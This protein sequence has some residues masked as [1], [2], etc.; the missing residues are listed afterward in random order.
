[1]PE[2]ESN[3]EIEESIPKL[4]G[5]KLLFS[6][7]GRVLLEYPQR[8]WIE[9]LANESV[10][11][12]IPFATKNKDVIAGLELLQE[13]SQANKSGLSESKFYDI[14]ADYTRLFI[15][16]GKVL[17]PPWESVYLSKKKILF[18]E[19]TL[20][21]R[22]WYRRFGLESVKIKNE[23]DDHIG[24]EL[25]FLAN[26]TNLCMT[27]LEEKDEKQFEQIHQAKYQ[28]LQEHLLKWAPTWCE[29]VL[30]NTNTDFIRGITLLVRG[31]LSELAAEHKTT[32]A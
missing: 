18:Q 12:E 14:Q 17:A 30:D 11:E 3:T 7:L 15:G 5:Q 4:L 26:L 32:S 27:A 16:P 2:N 23:P 9:S 6:L 28:F 8:E 10:F 25:A 29:L 1:M 22:K 19:H 20:Q 13:W 21:V 24:L 31:S